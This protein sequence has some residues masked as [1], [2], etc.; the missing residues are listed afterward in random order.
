VTLNGTETARFP[1]QGPE[2][3]A[4]V[5]GS[6]FADWGAFGASATGRIALQDHGDKVWYKNIKIKRLH[7]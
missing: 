4:M 3:D 5:A 7:E 2:W 6:K 1:V